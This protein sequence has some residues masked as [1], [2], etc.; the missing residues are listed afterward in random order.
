MAMLRVAARHGSDAKALLTNEVRGGSVRARRD[1]R[2]NY[3][4]MTPTV[5]PSKRGWAEVRHGRSRCRLRSCSTTLGTRRLPSGLRCS[6][7][8]R[9]P[10]SPSTIRAGHYKLFAPPSPHNCRLARLKPLAMSIADRTAPQPV[11]VFDDERDLV[12]EAANLAVALDPPDPTWS[13]RMLLDL[14][15]GRPDHRYWAALIARRLKRPQDT[16]ATEASRRSSRGTCVTRLTEPEDSIVASALQH[17]LRDPGRKEP[18]PSLS[19]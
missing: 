2:R 11:S 9:T 19:S 1:R 6:I 15:S 4:L 5:W 10:R 3:Q 13:T 12:G 17:C 8:S 18:Q 7:Y 16:G 14:L